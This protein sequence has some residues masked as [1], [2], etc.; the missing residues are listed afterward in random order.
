MR[1][2]IYIFIFL[3]RD[4][5]YSHGDGLGLYNAEIKSLSPNQEIDIAVV[6]AWCL[7]VNGDVFTDGRRSR[8]AFNLNHNVSFV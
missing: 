6:S 3:I 8:F 4:C 7:D 1:T 5:Y 2:Y